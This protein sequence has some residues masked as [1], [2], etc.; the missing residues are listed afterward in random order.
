LSQS[1]EAHLAGWP[2]LSS[3]VDLCVANWH[4]LAREIIDFSYFSNFKESPDNG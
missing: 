1:P 2:D 3:K 4:S